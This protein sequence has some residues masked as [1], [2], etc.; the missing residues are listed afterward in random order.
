MCVGESVCYAGRTGMHMKFRFN[1]GLCAFCA[2]D[3]V[4]CST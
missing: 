1:M 4:L 3:C 2:G